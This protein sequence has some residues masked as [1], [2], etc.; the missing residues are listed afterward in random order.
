M[1]K[2][3]KMIKTIRRLI[4]IVYRDTESTF[5]EPVVINNSD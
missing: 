2:Y 4:R 5:D 1:L 3:K